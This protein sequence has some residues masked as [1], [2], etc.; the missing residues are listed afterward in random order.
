MSKSDCMYMQKEPPY[1][2]T[3][4]HITA[5]SAWSR[6]R[7]AQ[8]LW[9]IRHHPLLRK[10]APHSYTMSYPDMDYTIKTR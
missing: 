2:S 9:R 3:D 8:I 1:P 7:T 4:Q 6:E 5:S 10:D